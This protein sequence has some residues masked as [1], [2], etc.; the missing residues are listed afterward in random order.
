MG[1]HMPGFMERFGL[2][3]SMKRWRRALQSPGALSAGDLRAMLRDMRAMRA[4]LDRLSAD[5]GSVLLAR[6]SDAP[7]VDGQNDWIGRPA[8]WT[9]VMRP[10][11]MVDLA[12]PTRLP[13]GVTLFHDATRSDLSLRQEPAPGGE[14]T[15]FGLV[16]EVYRFDGS[17]VS[18]VHDLP[19]EA[20]RGLTLGHYI[21]VH[22]RAEREHPVEVYARLNV[23]HGPNVEQ[24]VRQV[25]FREDE[26]RAEFDLAYTQI[27]E[28]RIEKA[29]LDIILEG[30]EMTRIAIWD[31]LVMRAPRA[32]V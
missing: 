1:Q 3:Q 5:A 23:Q 18:L 19:E 30:P 29:W 10:R 6:A 20:V 28:R 7:H 12:S 2:G 26:G 14:A 15:R 8:P 31:V 9:S 17:F 4:R 24:M 11:G 27:N 22:I 32:D 25:D 21:S 13:G 16:L